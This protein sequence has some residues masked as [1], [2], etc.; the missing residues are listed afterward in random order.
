MGIGDNATLLGYRCLWLKMKALGTL[1]DMVLM[2]FIWR[3]TV[4]VSRTLGLSFHG[5]STVSKDYLWPAR[6]R[7]HVIEAVASDGIGTLS[8]FPYS[9]RSLRK[10]QSEWD[11]SSTIYDTEPSNEARVPSWLRSRCYSQYHPG[12]DQISRP[13]LIKTTF[14]EKYHICENAT[15]YK[16]NITG[17][18]DQ[19]HAGIGFC[20]TQTFIRIQHDCKGWS[21]GPCR[22]ST[23]SSPA[24]LEHARKQLSKMATLAQ[25]WT[26]HGY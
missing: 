16:S 17:Y 6:R 21:L 23:I 1:A 19:T 12:S 18:N 4:L 8:Q 7:P 26:E 13:F 11:S 24:K 9:M 3:P 2:Y 20:I 25:I 10:R 14:Y 5:K 15:M 22:I